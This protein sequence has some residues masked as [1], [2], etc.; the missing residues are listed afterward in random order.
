MPKCRENRR[1]RLKR[2]KADAE[3]RRSVFGAPPLQDAYVAFRFWFEAIQ[4]LQRG[5]AIFQASLA[6]FQPGELR[7]L[8][9]EPVR[10]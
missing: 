2:R 3:R 5:L 7:F 6:G 4:T 1:R 8:G 9:T 10:D